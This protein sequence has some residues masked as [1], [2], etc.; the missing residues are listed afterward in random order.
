M[1][2]GR[3]RQRS[4]GEKEAGTDRSFFRTREERRKDKWR[5][6]ENRKQLGVR[7]VI[8]EGELDPRG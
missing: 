3:E 6:K 1:C 2:R 7:E 5:R 8:R 4:R